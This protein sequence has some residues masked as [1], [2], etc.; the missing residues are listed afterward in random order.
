VFHIHHEHLYRTAFVC[1]GLKKR[2]EKGCIEFVLSAS[3]SICA[4]AK[5]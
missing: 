5:K 1:G 3:V 4:I 2:R